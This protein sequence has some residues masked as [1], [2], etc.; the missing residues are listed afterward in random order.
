MLERNEFEEVKLHDACGVFGMSVAEG[1][2]ID[3]A[4]D[5]YHALYALQHRGQQSC[6]IAVCT[7][8]DINVKKGDGLLSDVFDDRALLR[9][10]GR[11]AIGHVRYSGVGGTGSVHAQPIVVRHLGGS[12]AVAHNGQLVG[13]TKLRREIELRGGIFQS[14]GDAELIAYLIVKEQLTHPSLEEAV[15]AVMGYMRGA[16]SLVIMSGQ[17][18]IAVRDPSGYRPL[19]MGKIGDSVIFASESCAFDAIGAAF[20]RDIAPGEIVVAERGE[21]KSIPT[22]IKARQALCCFEF[23]YFARPDSVIDNVSVELA[24]Q[25]A[26]CCLAKAD[27][28]EADV[29]IGVPDSG[30]SAALGYA[31]VSGIPYAVGLVKNR[32]IGRTFIQTTQGQRERAVKIKLNALSAVLRDKRVVMVDDS[33]VRGT[34][35][36][37]LVS[38]VREAGAK[39]VHMRISSP[40]FLHPCYYG[41]DIPSREVLAAHNRTVEEVNALI[42]ADSLLYLPLEDVGTMLTGLSGGYCEACFTGDYVDKPEE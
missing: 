17:K 30:I 40:P 23:V 11:T 9:L 42:G 18:L 21:V 25:E 36:A 13:A 37:H 8:E 19:C 26:G 32:Y 34:T 28:I 3:A 15:Q 22:G 14:E 2:D 31:R 24:R 39:E 33:I 12:L 27:N 16:Y 29:V 38:L 35:C 10:R 4:M 41:T 1:D 7:G 6:G 5:T 20:V